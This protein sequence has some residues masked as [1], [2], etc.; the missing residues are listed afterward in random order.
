[1]ARVMSTAELITRTLR[2]GVGA[3][4]VGPS[5][6]DGVVG[7]TDAPEVF[8][9]FLCR[10]GVE[11]L[12]LELHLHVVLEPRLDRRSLERG[13][14][15]RQAV[16]APRGPHVDEHELVLGL[17][18]F[19]TLTE[20]GIPAFVQQLLHAVG[21]LGRV[22]P[23]LREQPVTQNAVI[24]RGEEDEDA[25]GV[26]NIDHPGTRLGHERQPGARDRPRHGHPDTEEER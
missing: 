19:E 20:R 16:L 23:A 1:M 13:L 18:R 6:K 10:R 17:R 5:P 12:G 8:Q 14:V 22:D 15:H 9:D 26:L 25:E 7:Q 3:A 2:S 24:T 11:V 21:H 4:R